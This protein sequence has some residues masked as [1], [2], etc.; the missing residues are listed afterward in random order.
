MSIHDSRVVE[1]SFGCLLS[2]FLGTLIFLRGFLSLGVGSLG[3]LDVRSS[4]AAEANVRGEAGF[5]TIPGG[6]LRDPFQ[7]PVWIQGKE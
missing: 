4:L 6:H 2:S 3:C 5:V 1:G 7:Y